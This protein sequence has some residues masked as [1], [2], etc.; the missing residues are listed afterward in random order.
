ML[1]RENIF[2]RARVIRAISGWAIVALFTACATS[3]EQVDR[4]VSDS[5]RESLPEIPGGE[6]IR[7]EHI[8]ALGRGLS[9]R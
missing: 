5:L 2:S 4:E 7:A 1:L 9:V 6:E 8:A 3:S